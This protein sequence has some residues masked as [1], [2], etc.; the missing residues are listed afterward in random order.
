MNLH[1]NEILEDTDNGNLYR[2]LWIDNESQYIYL[3]DVHD[4]KAL[5][6]LRD[7]QDVIEE[8][9]QDQLQKNR[10]FIFTSK[11]PNL[12]TDKE[13]ALRNLAWDC[14]KDIVDEEPHIYIP[15]KRG[16][17]IQEILQ[18]KDVTKMTI[19]KYLRKYWQKGKNIDT[20]IPNYINC[21]GR[22]KSKNSSDKKRGRPAKLPDEATQI[23][24]DENIRRI[25]HVAL[26]KYYLNKKNNK[27]TVAYKLMIR[28][29][30]A[31]DYYYEDGVKK[32]IIADRSQIPSFRQFRYWYEKDYSIGNSLE[33]RLGTKIFNKDHRAVL[34]SST[35]ETFGPGSRF[36]IDA[37]IADVYLISQYNTNWIIGRPVV[38][39]V[40]DVFSRMI[41]GVYV[42]LEGPS[43]LGAMMAIAN[44]VEDKQKFCRELGIEIEKSQWPCEHLPSV[45][46]A[47]RGE[48]EGYN[49]DRLIDAFNL[50]VENAAPYRADWKGI[51][52]RMFKTIQ[53]RV[54]PF[55][56][57]FIDVDFRQRGS[58][59]YRLDAKLTLQDF[60]KL[61][62]MNILDYNNN[63]YLK[64]Y[65]RDKNLVQ[66]DIVPKPIHLWNW[67]I[68]NRSGKLR[69]Y[70][71]DIVKIH[72]LPREKGTISFK[73][74]KFKDAYYSCDKAIKENWFISA[75]HKGSWKIDIVY[76]PRNLNNLYLLN[77][78]GVTFEVCYLLEHQ[79]RYLNISKDEMEYLQEYEK[80][81]VKQ[82][83]YEQLQSDINLID[84]TEALIKHVIKL[85]DQNQTEDLN[86][87]ER[88][89]N[90]VK[91]RDNEKELQR[92]KEQFHLGIDKK[93]F[94]TDIA[95]SPQQDTLSQFKRK[96]MKEL[97]REGDE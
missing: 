43:W 52:E 69:Y 56:P 96:S 77:E 8:I 40:I 10:D 62:V 32:V 4:S 93:H 19:Y 85:A 58:R 47:D 44:T 81:L 36:Q 46:L 76:D 34:G 42:G 48:F 51:V 63:H 72:L 25:F 17:L 21:G 13:K 89:K 94:T 12:L 20:L 38:Y 29:F 66:D 71:P 50:H 83:E 61:I 64:Y 92:E 39:L 15:E 6:F 35:Y 53:T 70:A 7:V 16:P 14:I 97:L 5:P 27:L 78:D 90:I 33:L 75:R 80:Q 54:K 24:V 18:K 49:V 9:V 68:K 74:I 95:K 28:E 67:G 57:G 88:V 73:G 2:I 30:F 3:I 60:T 31:D 22:G 82:N 91:N 45:L 79:N 1:V 55:L 23:N 41:G 84:D 87:S 26:V 65:L 11:S 37:T 86:K 59:D